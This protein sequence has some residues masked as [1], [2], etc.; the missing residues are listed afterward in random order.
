MVDTCS[1]PNTVYF[2]EEEQFAYVHAVLPAALYIAIRRPLVAILIVYVFESFEQAAGPFVSFFCESAQKGLLGDPAQGAA[3][4]LGLWIIDQ[5][6]GWDLAFRA[7]V[8]GWLRLLMFIFLAA[9]S[10]FVPTAVQTETVNWGILIYYAIYI[11]FPLLF[12][13]QVVFNVQPGD[14]EARQAG[15]SVILWLVLAAAWTG[16]ALINTEDGQLGIYASLWCRVFYISL[17]IIA[18]GLLWYAYIR[19]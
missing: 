2:A 4:I 8:N 7:R 5:V 13:N 1:P 6:W 16:V 19:P 11:F 17:G 15:R 3:A 18:M 9:A 12:F 14:S 10:P